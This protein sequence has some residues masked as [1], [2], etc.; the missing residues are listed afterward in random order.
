MGRN[1]L[2]F[3]LG[4]L[5]LPFAA[6]WIMDQRA[7]DAVGIV[8]YTM[9]EQFFVSAAVAAIAGGVCGWIAA[10]A[11]RI[12][13]LKGTIGFIISWTATA[14]LLSIGSTSHAVANQGTWGP[15]GIFDWLPYYLVVTALPLAITLVASYALVG[16]ARLPPHP[17]DLKEG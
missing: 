16:F 14:C 8:S 1:T 7:A 12:T 15:V 13:R 10:S 3:I 17:Q 9:G 5:I 11:A 2:F 4:C 6:G